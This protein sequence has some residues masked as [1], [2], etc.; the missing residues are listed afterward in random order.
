M[1]KRK[2]V[3]AQVYAI[4]I[5]ISYPLCYKYSIQFLQK[6]FPYLLPSPLAHLGATCNVI[7]V[8]R[9]DVMGASVAHWSM[10]SAMCMQH[11][12]HKGDPGVTPKSYDGISDTAQV[13][14]V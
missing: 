13:I 5:F 2:Y 7:R 12:E 11:H 3:G 10:R 14:L 4:A 9:R 1:H 8:W 6:S